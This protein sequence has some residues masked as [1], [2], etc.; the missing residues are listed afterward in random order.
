MGVSGK[1]KELFI[2][3]QNKIKRKTNKTEAEG[4]RWTSEPRV[5]RGGRRG[6][7]NAVAHSN[8]R[9][10]KLRDFS[11]QRVS[12]GYAV[13]IPTSEAARFDILCRKTT[14]HSDISGLERSSLFSEMG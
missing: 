11:V 2:D 9:F 10:P 6:G 12:C 5:L 1:S 7:R 14:G 8:Q 13:P 4:L 3:P